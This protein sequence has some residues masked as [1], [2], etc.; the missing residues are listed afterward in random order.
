MTHT[1]DEWVDYAPTGFQFANEPHS[2]RALAVSWSLLPDVPVISIAG[3]NGKGSCVAVLSHLLRQQGHRVAT[4]SSPHIHHVTERIQ[5]NG[6]SITKDELWSFLEV[7]RAKEPKLSYF[8]QLL[9]A[10]MMY[11][12]SQSCDYWVMEVGL[13]GR[14]DAVN[15]LDADIAIITSIDLDHQE[16][17]GHTRRHIAM[18]K[19]GIAR[20]HRPLIVAEPDWPEVSFPT[21]QV[22][23][24]NHDFKV[25]DGIWL[26]G[27]HQ[28]P[29]AQCSL[30]PASVAA[31]L[32]ALECLELWPK[33]GLSL[34]GISVPGRLEKWEVSNNI[35]IFDVAHNDASLGH[36]ANQMAGF[37]GVVVFE[38]RPDK[39]VL[40]GLKKLAKEAQVMWLLRHY[41]DIEPQ[42][43]HENNSIRP[44]YGSLDVLLTSIDRSHDQTILVTGS[45][46]TVTKAQAWC[47]QHHA[48][49]I[50]KVTVD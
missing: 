17:L 29:I 26:S 36:L 50:K 3:T 8:E 19:V 6:Q 18:E 1:L 20:S 15:L 39:S 31:A 43:N 42:E 37:D 49:A 41:D 7:I 28:V 5:I 45:F 27:Q 48:N 2:L 14:L 35:F 9:L 10:G 12:K 4:F 38:A 22:H 47:M 11:F 30:H 23:R 21:K 34:K 13:G 24:I 16:V 44:Y 40:K 32:K 33:E 46:T 25:H